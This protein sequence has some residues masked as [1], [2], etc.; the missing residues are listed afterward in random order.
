MSPEHRG[1]SG[2]LPVHWRPS[3]P[4][5]LSLALG[6]GNILLGVGLGLWV[7]TWI[8]GATGLAAVA[9]F[10]GLG[11]AVVVAA[12]G[13]VLWWVGRRA[14]RSGR[15]REPAVAGGFGAGIAL[16]MAVAV[17][18]AIGG[19]DPL[20][21]YWS[22][23]PGVIGAVLGWKWSAWIRQRQE[24]A[25]ETAVLSTDRPGLTGLA[26][27]GLG[28][29]V[30]AA[31]SVVVPPVGLAILGLGLGTAV[32]VPGWYWLARPAYRRLNE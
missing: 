32:V 18:T 5:Y 2:D 11:V 23:L 16:S 1:E 6:V 8:G 24:V 30:G 17:V 15:V 25:S 29:V 26:A 7:V 31:A 27:G 12:Y 19:G 14:L 21:N 3:T 10:I 20:V 28:V 13:A 4:A 22:F 9:A